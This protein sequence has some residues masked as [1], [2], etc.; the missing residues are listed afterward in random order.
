MEYCERCSCLFGE[1]GRCP[2]CRRRFG[3]EAQPDDPV[4]LREE[5]TLMG[6]ILADVLRQAGVPFLQRQAVGVAPLVGQGLARYRFYVPLRSL[7]AARAAAEEALDA[8]PEET[9]ADE[10]TNPDE[11]E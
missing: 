10:E 6:S 2:L 11:E 5:G 1:D 3:R 4:F 8:D 9:G 7:E